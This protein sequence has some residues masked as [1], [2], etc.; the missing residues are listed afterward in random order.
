MA[1]RYQPDQAEVMK[2][3]EAIG[4]ASTVR[5]VAR[6]IS[7]MQEHKGA[8]SHINTD[9]V[10]RE[11]D[12]AVSD[13]RIQRLTGKQLDT[14]GVR[15]YGMRADGVYY[16]THD[17]VEK[18][19][20]NFERAEEERF[21]ARIDDVITRAV[22]NHH[23]NETTGLRRILRESYRKRVAEG[24]QADVARDYVLTGA[25]NVIRHYYGD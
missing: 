23:L 2:A 9:V 21:F 8:L 17:L 10:K 25:D 4:K 13:N 1:K 20:A 24:V 6:E 16:L 5:D 7:A 22:L 18:L 11:L 12:I 15:L 19:L 3:L 14:V